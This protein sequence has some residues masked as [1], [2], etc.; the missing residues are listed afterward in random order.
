MPAARRERGEMRPPVVGVVAAVE[1]EDVV[2]AQPLRERAVNE[3]RAQRRLLRDMR[4]EPLPL[5]RDRRAESLDPRALR[6]RAL[7]GL[8]GQLRRDGPDVAHEREGD[9]PIAPRL[10]RVRLNLDHLRAVRNHGAE[11]DGEVQHLAQ[12]ERG[13]RLADEVRGGVLAEVEESEAV[14]MVVR[15]D[16]AG[17]LFREERDFRRLN[18][19]LV[20]FAPVAVSGGRAR[21]DDRTLRLAQDPDGLRD[22]LAGR[23]DWLR[24]PVGIPRDETDVVF[25]DF[26]LDVDGDGEVRGPAPAFERHPDRRRSEVGNAARV[27]RQPRALRH[28]PRDADLI[29]LLHCAA[30]VVPQ[31]GGARDIEDRALG[32]HCVD[33]A[34]QGVRVA[35]RG[36]GDDAQF[37]GDARPHLRHMNGGLLV[38]AIHEAESLVVQRVQQR[39]DM[40]AG[41]REYRVHA[42]RPQRPRNN[43]RPAHRHSRAPSVSQRPMLAQALPGAGR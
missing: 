1:H 10:H 21:D 17:G 39:E 22:A 24:P 31:I 42:L 7:R 43:L 26:A 14:G 12:E 33:Q 9:A 5:L 32:G 18:Q 3:H 8:V 15:D 36:D 40:V 28:R 35:R 25:H 34:R 13:V 4:L 11:P 16:S 19:P 29:D 23:D 6:P 2:A 37:A 20:D 38:A 27:V 30:V 41:E